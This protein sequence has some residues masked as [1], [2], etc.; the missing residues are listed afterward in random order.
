[1]NSE[2]L[3]LRDECCCMKQQVRNFIKLWLNKRL[4]SSGPILLCIYQISLVL[5][6][7][8]TIIQFQL[9]AYCVGW[10]F[11]DNAMPHHPITNHVIRMTTLFVNIL[12]FL[13]VTE[14]IK[15]FVHAIR[16]KCD[17]YPYVEDL[18]EED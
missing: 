7:C 11:A 2:I 8:H 4:T 10:V 3:V 15:E 16:C 6:I 14:H 1:M 5:A 13:E 9:I 18:E 17:N 12:L